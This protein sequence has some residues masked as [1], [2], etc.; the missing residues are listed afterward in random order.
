[1]ERNMTQLGQRLVICTVL[2]LLPATARAACSQAGPTAGQTQNQAATPD[3]GVLAV[4]NGKRVITE[5]DINTLIGPEIEALQTKIKAIRRSAV[6][7]LVDAILLEDAAKARGITV[8]QLQKTMTPEKVE[9][10]E[11]QVEMALKSRP[12]VPP[13]K[14]AEVKAAIR[15]GLEIRMKEQY[16]KAAMA[17]L[18][19]EA[20]VQLFLED[21][22]PVTAPV[23]VSDSGPSTGA[24]NAPVTIIEF[25]D[26]QCPYCQQETA[27]LEQLLRTYSG[28]V[29]LVFKQMPLPSHPRSFRSAEASVCAASQGKFWEYHHK[30]YGSEDMS[31]AALR[32]YGSDVGLNAEEFDRCLNNDSARDSVLSDMREGQAVGVHITPSFVLNGKVLPGLTN[33]ETFK[34]NIDAELAKSK[35]EAH[36]P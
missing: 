34:A 5:K 15:K 13:D 12:P 18:R 8:D 16:F 21:K 29:R 9:V 20:N 30:L 25:A 27:T 23:R 36:K 2:I 32:R 3:S 14:V 35:P 17:Q 19:S 33:L 4:V 22:T 26:F 11:A 24:S 6:D 28:K 10:D 31:E 1:M 7:S